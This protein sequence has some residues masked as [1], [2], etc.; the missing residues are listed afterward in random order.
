MKNISV[1]VDE[2]GDFGFNEKSSPYYVIT[3]V[4]HDQSFDISEKINRLNE[5]LLK[6]G[7]N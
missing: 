7:F 5:E 6:I 3:M 1:F 2:S 4:F